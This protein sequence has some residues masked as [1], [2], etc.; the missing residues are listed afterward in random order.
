M[1]QYGF[2][3][4]MIRT[5]TKPR[6]NR[7]GASPTLTQDQN[8]CM[9]L[10]N[11]TQTTQVQKVDYKTIAQ[12]SQYITATVSRILGLRIRTWT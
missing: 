5:Q 10:D 3:V 8:P 6:A 12:V 2:Y 7:N 1:Y 11:Q 9:K 4:T